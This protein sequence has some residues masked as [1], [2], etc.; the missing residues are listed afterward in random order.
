M[1]TAERPRRADRNE[2]EAAGGVATQR[3]ARA[4]ARARASAR[5]LVGGGGGARLEP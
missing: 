2:R 5:A 1:N 4:R 3:R